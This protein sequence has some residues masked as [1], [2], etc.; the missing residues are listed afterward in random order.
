MRVAEGSIIE[1]ETQGLG[2]RLGISGTPYTL[3]YLSS[4]Q[5]GFTAGALLDVEV[6]GAWISPSLKR[7]DVTVQVAGQRIVQS[8]TN[9]QPNMRL[10]VAWNGQDG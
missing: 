3:N 9:P 1:C 8:V 2:E 5:P 10:P 7:I 6:S 4:R